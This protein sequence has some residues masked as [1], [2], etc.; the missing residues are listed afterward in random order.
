L[1]T[2]AAQRQPAEAKYSTTLETRDPDAPIEA[3]NEDLDDPDLLPEEE[4]DDYSLPDDDEE[5]ASPAVEPHEE[6]LV[7]P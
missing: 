6:P 3:P 4:D 2:Q 5:Y 7:T 1:R